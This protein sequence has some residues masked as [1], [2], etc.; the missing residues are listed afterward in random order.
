MFMRGASDG[1][2]EDWLLRTQDG[3]CVPA[4]AGIL[5]SLADADPECLGMIDEMSLA[6]FDV[7]LLEDE[8]GTRERL[9]RAMRAE[10]LA[11]LRW[12]GGSAVECMRWLDTRDVDV[13]L[14]DLRLPDGS[15]IEV[16][17]HCRARQPRCDVMVVT[18]FADQS[19]MIDAFAAGA[20]G[21]LLKDGTEDELARHVRNLRAG[22]SPMSPPIARALLQLWNTSGVAPAVVDA[23][24][25]LAQS[26][27]T[28]RETDVLGLI[29]RGFTYD[30]AAQRLGV[31][32]ATV[33]TH[34]R[35]IYAKLDVHNKV[36]AVFE[37]RALGLLK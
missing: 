19:K 10:P 13:L 17:G 15:G 24:Q 9:I 32:V 5:L 8:P 7:A 11:R 20:R 33:R 4:N 22:G 26:S 3:G 29:A 28:A 6:P 31:A 14:V 27:L 12:A 21:Y 36:E 25:D 34:I 18:M 35:A 16:I 30:E 37:A 1:I 23:R 2:D